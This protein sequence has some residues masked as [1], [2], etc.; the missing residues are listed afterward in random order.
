MHML[1]P[2][3][4]NQHLCKDSYT[5]PSSPYVHV[6][7]IRPRMCF[8]YTI[9]LEHRDDWSCITSCFQLRNNCN[10]RVPSF[11]L[12]H[13]E[14]VQGRVASVVDEG[15]V[16][17]GSVRW[18]WDSN[19]NWEQHGTDLCFFCSD[20]WGN[21]W[22]NTPVSQ[23]HEKN[24]FC[25]M[26]EDLFKRIQRFYGTPPVNKSINQLTNHMTSDCFAVCDSTS[27]FSF[28]QSDDLC[29]FASD[30]LG[31]VLELES[32]NILQ[33]LCFD[34]PCVLSKKRM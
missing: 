22:R 17:V 26:D 14:V 1:A 13:V 18:F 23:K 2:Q 8:F 24:T 20:W 16:G 30:I 28:F 10:R 33:K 5:L 3:V 4:E 21:L 7:M 11:P 31:Y 12:L 27:G 34:G 32:P 29:C 19:E 25:F 15:G 9:P 6:A